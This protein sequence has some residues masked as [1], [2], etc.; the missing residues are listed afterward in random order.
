MAFRLAATGNPAAH[1]TEFVLISF[2][3]GS[4]SSGSR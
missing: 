4:L 1:F 2:D 3:E